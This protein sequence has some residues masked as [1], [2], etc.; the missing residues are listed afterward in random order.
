MGSSEVVGVVE[1]SVDGFDVVAE[2][3]E[4]C[5]VGVVR[6]DGSEILCPVESACEV[7]LVAVESDGDFTAAVGVGELVS[8][9]PAVGVVGAG[10]SVGA[11]SFQRFEGWFAVDVWGGDAEG[12][13]NG[14]QADGGCGAVGLGDD[15]VFD[16]P[17]GWHALFVGVAAW[18][19]GAG[20]FGLDAV[21]GDPSVVV[22]DLLVVYST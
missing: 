4:P 12:T 7:V 18:V 17:T 9:V 22:Q 10:A 20:L 3:V 16:V 15:S 8:V 6:W 21:D 11:E 14:E 19:L 1:V 2:R 5:E 13:V